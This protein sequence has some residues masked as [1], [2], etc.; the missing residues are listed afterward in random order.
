M[1]WMK[2]PVCGKRAGVMT[3]LKVNSGTVLD[4][5]TCAKC[6]VQIIKPRFKND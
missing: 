6:D 4:F 3:S 1:K 5:F 2:C